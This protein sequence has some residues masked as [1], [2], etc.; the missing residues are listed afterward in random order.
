MDKQQTLLV[1]AA[2]PDDAEGGAGGTAA[3]YVRAGHKVV[4]LMV[5]KGE[6]GTI[7][8]TSEEIARI[9][10]EE[11]R[12]A[13]AILGAE[14][15]FL[16]FKDGEVFNH[17]PE[18][19]M[20][21][22]DTIREVKPDIIITHHPYELHPDEWVVGRLSVDAFTLAGLPNIKTQH[23][24][25]DEV[26]GF[27]MYADPHRFNVL[28]PQ[29]VT[30]VVDITETIELKLKALEEFKSQREFMAKH[31]AYDAYMT[32]FVRQQRAK[33]EAVGAIW[34]CEYGEP[35]VALRGIASPFLPLSEK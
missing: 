19:R 13:S 3:K 14:P 34:G 7:E 2:H 20:A 27:F 22:V 25:W 30:H 26:K 28:V 35:F 5:T 33:A 23:K 8:H 9:R 16:D 29:K 11:E 31:G 1:I 24:S 32:D 15:K 17:M 18:V 4:F 12:R 6:A 21:L 10:V